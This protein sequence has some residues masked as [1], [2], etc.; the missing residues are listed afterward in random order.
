MTSLSLL[1][2]T[3]TFSLSFL[4]FFLQIS[5]SIYFYSHLRLNFFLN[6]VR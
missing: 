5:V 1:D 3:D 2:I 4:I 6:Q